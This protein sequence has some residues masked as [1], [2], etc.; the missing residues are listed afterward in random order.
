MGWV[1]AGSG[2]RE[3]GGNESDGG[4][5]KRS[6]ENIK[7]DREGDKVFM[8]SDIFMKLCVCLCVC[9]CLFNSQ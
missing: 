8:S 5:R 4:R 7:T 6:E 2:R 9:V 3:G 1:G